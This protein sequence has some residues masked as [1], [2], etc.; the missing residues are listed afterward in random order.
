MYS[1]PL[2]EVFNGTPELT[3]QVREEMK[4]E[5]QLRQESQRRIEGQVS[6]EQAATKAASS[7]SGASQPKPTA[8]KGASQNPLQTAFDVLAAPGQGLNDYF[9]DELNKLP[10]LKLKK[11]PVFENNA[12]QAVRNLSSFLGPM[13]L[14]RKAAGAAGSA[15]QSRVGAKLGEDAAFKWFAN[16]GLDIGVGAYVGATNKLSES[17]DNLA[18]TL[19][20]AWPQQYSWISDDWATLDTDSPDIKRAKNIN[21]GVA[22]DAFTS[23]VGAAIKLGWAGRGVKKATE[24]IPENEL[25]KNNLPKLLA[26]DVQLDPD[27]GVNYVLQSVKKSEDALDE[28]GAYNL[29]KSV[30]L[31]EPVFGVHNVYDQYESAIRTVD[32]DG[33]LGASVD[34]V[35]IEKNIGTVYGRVGSVMS[36]AALKY[37]LEVDEGGQQVVRALA[38]QLKEAGEYGYKTS[39][40]RYISHAEVADVGDRLAA[41]FMQM[42]VNDM[43][44]V[45]AP[46]SG[47]DPD[48]GATV[49]KSEAYAGV[50]KA[51]KGYLNEFMN[52]DYVRAQAYVNTSFAGQVSDM[53]QGLR[54][55]DGT[56][57]V[58]RAQEQILDRLE[59]LMTQKGVTSYARGRA[60]NMLNLWSQ[61]K[62]GFSG[63]SAEQMIKNERNETLKAIQ[64]IAQE[65][66]TT[67]NTLRE[68][69]EQ[70]PEMLGP[71]MLAYE[72]T[73]G[74]IDTISKLN[75]Y[76]QKKNAVFS[77]MLMDF[78]PDTP[79]AWMQGVWSNIYNSTLSA[80]GTPIKAGVSNLVL[81]L[82][83]P[84]ATMAGALING[85]SAVL[86]RGWYQYTGA[87]DTLQKAYSHMSDVFRRASADPNSVGYIVRDDIVRQNEDQLTVMKA[88]AEA[89]EKEGLYGPS[90]MLTKIEALNDLAEHPWLRFG[91]NAMAAF[92][93][94]TRSVIAN[95]EARGQAYDLINSVGNKIDPKTLK[96]ISDGVYSSMFDDTGMITDK[97]VDHAS[98]EIAMNLDNPA[99]D[100]ISALINRAPILRPFMMF[101]KTSINMLAFTGSHNPLGL[102]IEQLNAFELPF[103]KL[104]LATSERLLTSRGIPFDDNAEIA[105]ETIR[106]EL[107]GRKA[108]GTLSVIGAVGM[109]LTDRLRGNGIYDKEK[110]KLRTNSGW[111]PRTYMGADGRWYSYDNLGAISD[112][113]A[114]TADVMDNFDSLEEPTIGTFLNKMGY[115]LT[116]NLTNKSFLAG[117][118]PMNDVL[119]GRPDA[120]SRWGASFISSM[121]PGSGLRNEMSRLMTPQL[122]E[123]EQELGQ[124]LLNRNPIVKDTLPDMHD[125]VD[126]G[127]VG[128]PNS[129][130]TRIWNTYMP[131][132]S[133]DKISPEKQFLIDIEYDARPT[134][135]TNGKGIDYS[136]KERA[137]VTNLM[138]QDGIFKNE[139]QKIMSS[140]SGKSFRKAFKDAQAQG[141]AVDIKDFLNI[142]RELDYALRRA[143]LYAES[144]IDSRDDVLAKQYIN[145]ESGRQS[146]L[147]DIKEILRINNQ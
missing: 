136:P 91:S 22:L 73:D 103:S 77:R 16:R 40:G 27:P 81:L 107:K 70:R 108:I 86:R 105:Y 12:V 145:E 85:E 98:R 134:L 55:M 39:N 49:L 130:W 132:K 63:Q 124:L 93:G 111:K 82:E 7:S 26:E 88:F 71:L 139:I 32:E 57:A 133:H 62:R 4:L 101:P 97:A 17:D 90:V 20:K 69:K 67:I 80:F 59:F 2:N 120:L 121:V 8:P 128:M 112:W 52:L 74:K 19:K 37:G 41:D 79:S 116:A 83:R 89:K 28:I 64:R 48:T 45:L 43:K 46:L 25:A 5:E 110:Q 137:Q 135:Q 66:K 126:G 146:R 99:V 56:S 18:G 30:N 68:V 78:N 106:A 141:A 147:G 14:L 75:T 34:A 144:R 58:E 84:V 36:E 44:R 47:I 129:I 95:W 13:L 94:F 142:H 6:Q 72:V 35:R 138:G 11:R 54:L 104:D 3:Q 102:F 100:A 76:I 117:L 92:D 119:A 15:A 53:A 115:L 61:V 50:F 65:S 123:V 9:V 38:D 114:L 127:K 33:I 51:I 118:E 87:I 42:E 140:T 24:W 1:N 143:Q 113:L 21:E 109:M 29:S 122:K 31:D 96:S 131:W 10:F 60:L 23:I 125:W